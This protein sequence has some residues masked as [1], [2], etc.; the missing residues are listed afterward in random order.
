MARADMTPLESVRDIQGLVRSGYGSLGAATILLLRVNDAEAARQWLRRMHPGI[1]TAA[2]H[3]PP[4]EQVLQVAF[5]VEGLRALELDEDVLAGFSTEFLSGM[6]GLD[7]RSRRLGDVGPDAP[8]NWRWGAGSRVPHLAV[9]LIAK[10][11]LLSA[12]RASVETEEWGRAFA[13]LEELA[14]TDMGEREPFGFPDGLSQP[15]VDWTGRRKPSTDADLAYGNLLAAGEFLLGYEN[16][17][18][19]YTDRPLIAPAK[20]PKNLLL[21]A[22]DNPAMRDFGLNGTFLVFRHLEQDVRGFWRFL[23]S[24]SGSK[25]GARTALAEKIIGRTLDTG[26]P[27]APLTPGPIPGI[28]SDDN[29]FTFDADPDG[30]R[31]PAGAHIRRAN[32]RTGDMPGGRQGKISQI[33]TALGLKQHAGDNDLIAS[34]RFHRVIRRGRKYGVYTPPEQ[35]LVASDPLPPTGLYFMCLSANILRQYEF[36]QAAWLTGTAFDGMTGEQD[37]MLGNRAGLPAGPPAA[38]FGV[39]QADGVCRR[40]DPMAKFVSVRGG[41][42]FFLPGLRALSHIAGC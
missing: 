34:S 1:T 33:L 41:A 10:A 30:V 35:A 40:I 42:Y 27:L 21:S 24:Q 23:D 18:G 20:D 32:P 26:A 28:N 13:P 19:H 17:Y 4:V 31:C 12:L 37:P 5:T 7:N 25:P 9:I 38:A 11:P 22:A 29:R 2:M 15:Q 14:T 8:A 6:A 39:P 16:E 36:V 3:D